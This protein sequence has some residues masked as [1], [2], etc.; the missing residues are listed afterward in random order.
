MISLFFIL[1]YSII[2][3]YDLLFF[4]MIMN[5]EYYDN[6]FK[7]YFASNLTNLFKNFYFQAHF[8]VLTDNFQKLPGTFVSYFKSHIYFLKAT[9]LTRIFFKLSINFTKTAFFYH[10]LHHKTLL[11]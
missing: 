5:I 9:F 8:L 3:Y 10:F 11:L 6:E 4:I 7:L 2:L 1:L